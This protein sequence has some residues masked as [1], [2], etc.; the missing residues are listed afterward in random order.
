MARVLYCLAAQKLNI[1]KISYF[2]NDDQTIILFLV[3][4]RRQALLF[5]AH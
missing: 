4:D 3:V 1:Q 2:V 5:A